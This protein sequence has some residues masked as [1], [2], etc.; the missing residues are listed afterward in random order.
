[1]SRRVY[2]LGL[3]L[4][5]VALGLAVTDAMIGP[6]PGVTEAN[7]RRIRNGMTMKEVEAILGGPGKWE[8]YLMD[9]RFR[10]SR[11]FSWAGPDGTAHIAFY[12]KDGGARTG[13]VGIILDTDMVGSVEF[14]RTSGP[15]PGPF[16]RL[17]AWL[18][19]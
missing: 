3:G 19:W 1:M 5:L 9:N 14:R 10:G 17:R 4:A 6:S 13:V 8:F 11:H 7:V 15:S 16:A 2:L 18:G 12:E